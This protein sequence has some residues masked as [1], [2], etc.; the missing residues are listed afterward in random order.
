[1]SFMPGFMNS[2]M[3]GWVKKLMERILVTARDGTAAPAGATLGVS[4][5]RP[6]T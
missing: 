6:R 2:T 3:A 5:A 4:A 1:M